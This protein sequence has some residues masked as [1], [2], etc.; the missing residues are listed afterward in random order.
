M[1]RCWCW[2]WWENAS[3]SDV[4]GAVGCSW[5]AAGGHAGVAGS[6]A[7]ELEQSGH[8]L[9]VAVH[10]LKRLAVALPVRE[11]AGPLAPGEDRLPQRPHEHVRRQPGVPTVAFREGVDEDQPVVE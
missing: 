2:C 11:H 8:V 3:V 5:Q 7:G 4:T 6:A 10:C 9:P 1:D